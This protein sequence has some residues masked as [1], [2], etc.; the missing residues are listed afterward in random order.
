MTMKQL[1]RE[2]VAM[3]AKR[4]E[5]GMTLQPECRSD[6]EAEREPT[7]PLDGFDISVARAPSR[8]T[9]AAWR[10]RM[11][12]LPRPAVRLNR[13]AESWDF[14]SSGSTKPKRPRPAS[15]R[16]AN[17]SDSAEVDGTRTYLNEI[18][19][20][21]LLTAEQEQELGAAIER[22]R[23]I[24]AVE[25]RLT[26]RLAHSPRPVQVWIELLQQ[27]GELR[28]LSEIIARRLYLHTLPLDELI[29]HDR[30]RE[31]VDGMIT[32]S[33]SARICADS[34]LEQE[35]ASDLTIGLSVV[36]AILTP[37]LL[38]RSIAALGGAEQLQ[39]ASEQAATALTADDGLAR[40]FSKRL[41]EV[42][43]DGYDAERTMYVSNLRLVVSVAKKYQHKGLPFLDLIQEGNVGLFR[44]VEKF[45]YRK[46]NKFSTYA[47]WWIRQAATRALSDTSNLIR[48]PVHTAELINKLNRV[49]RRL[50]QE[51]QSQP[52]DEELAAELGH[53]EDRV[54]AL[55][56][57]ALS[58]ASLDKSVSDE[59]DDSELGSFLT[60]SNALTPEEELL[61][62]AFNG[63]TR[64]ALQRL[65]PRAAAVLSMRFGLEDGHEYTLEQV[66]ERF[67]LT[68]ERIRQIQSQAYQQLRKDPQ[69]LELRQLS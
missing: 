6:L 2:G 50:Q 1:D 62:K 10:R 14:A 23:W 5:T 51:N 25:Q 13:A 48:V 60:D 22:A 31:A 49:E 64:W 47:T 3:D 33:L 35:A 41:T 58:P 36:S 24:D 7:V 9:A 28:D 65:E 38:R 27:L 15:R 29:G 26:A 11:S 16:R 4:E 43:W 44:A 68:R 45:D 42:K 57:I 37:R 63:A 30:F 8:V 46:G 67:G 12:D 61:R 59:D 18:G 34:D 69:L 56:R 55:K 20:R 21:P 52:S 40:R 39:L 19:R 54:R 17:L 53:T 32:P 66:G